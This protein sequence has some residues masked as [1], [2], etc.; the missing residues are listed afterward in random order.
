M[1]TTHCIALHPHIGVHTHKFMQHSS[2][3]GCRSAAIWTAAVDKCC[4][5]GQNVGNVGHTSKKIHLAFVDPHLQN[6]LKTALQLLASPTCSVQAEKTGS[7]RKRDDVAEDEAAAV[8][9]KAFLKEFAAL[10]L[11]KLDPDEA[12]RQTADLYQQL[13]SDAAEMPALRQMLMC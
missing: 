7:K 1:G 5:S 11:D 13:E 2:F 3:K 12:V 9:A 8:R 4:K 10:P 6:L